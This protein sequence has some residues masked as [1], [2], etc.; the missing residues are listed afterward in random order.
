MPSKRKRSLDPRGLPP[1]FRANPEIGPLRIAVPTAPTAFVTQDVVAALRTLGHQVMELR[2]SAI[3]ET[4]VYDDARENLAPIVD[5]VRKFG[6]HMIL[7]V[8]L[9]GLGMTRFFAGLAEMEGVPLVTWL[10]DVAVDWIEQVLP[11]NSAFVQI[12]TYD[13]S[14]IEPLRRKGYRHVTYLPLGANPAHFVPAAPSAAQPY[15]LGYVGSLFTEQIAY[16]WRQLAAHSGGGPQAA[17]EMGQYRAAFDEGVAHFAPQDEP[18]QT[19]LDWVRRL[20]PDRWKDPARQMPLV[21]RFLAPAIAH[22]ASAARRRR[23]AAR[24]SDLGLHVWGDDA[25]RETADPSR[26]HPAIRYSDLG[27]IYQR[28]AVSLSVSHAQNVDSVTQRLFDVPAAGGFLLSD[29]RPSMA[30]LFVPGEELI[31]FRSDDEAHELAARYLADPAARTAVASRARARVLAEH[32]YPHRL[33]RLVG[34]TLRLWPEAAERP[35][36]HR[37]LTLGSSPAVAA[38]LLGLV[39]SELAKGGM[40]AQTRPILEALESVPEARRDALVLRAQEA[41]AAGDAAGS[42]RQCI[43]I[44]QV[45]GIGDAAIAFTAGQAAQQCEGPSAALSYFLTAAM[46]RQTDHVVWTSVAGCYLQLADW[47]RAKAALLRALAL[48]PDH[49]PALQCTQAFATELAAV[50]PLWD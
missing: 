3:D 50:E 41:L 5:R 15:P 24:L 12:F 7:N 9:M 10:V 49:A 39:A 38:P 33:E 43:E 45:H 46:M 11:P 27:L 34:E 18:A 48:R 6:P 40:Q 36:I 37:I 13:R 42:L 23:L 25:W 14:Q 44:M 20:A 47:P 21:P 32:T 16:S 19:A 35:R 31:A 2:Y 1:G 17:E 29:W 4:I 26:C 30:D 22:A 8:N 28:C